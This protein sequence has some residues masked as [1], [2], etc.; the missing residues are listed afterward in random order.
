MEQKE[1]GRL[2]ANKRTHLQEERHIKRL[3]RSKDLLQIL[4]A[5]DPKNTSI[6]GLDE[7][8]LSRV[9]LAKPDCRQTGKNK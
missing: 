6:G 1:T 9:C 7:I 4:S 5:F 3:K 2:S 8:I